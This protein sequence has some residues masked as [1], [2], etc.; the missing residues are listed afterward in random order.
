[1]KRLV[2]A[3]AML[4]GAATPGLAMDLKSADVS[5]GATFKT[6]FVCPRLGG[7]SISP[8]LSWSG[9]P[10]GTRSLALSMFDPDGNNHQGVWHWLVVDIPASTT[11]FAQGAGSGKAALPSGALEA[12]NS[13]GNGAY[14]G[15]CPP[16]GSGLHHYQIT[17]WAIG[18]A[19]AAVDASGKP[20]TTGAWI[21]QHA[22]AQARI[23]PVYQK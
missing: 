11:A 16:A 15:P 1:M 14:D 7:A 6:M 23:T 12:S 20:E 10:A 19:K 8:A 9:V 4:A 5:D 17:L 22:V 18:D 2:L 13:K 3:A 21:A